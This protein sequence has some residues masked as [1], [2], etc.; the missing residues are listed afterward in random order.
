[1][2]IYPELSYTDQKVDI[3]EVKGIQ[4]SV[5]GPDEIIAR[6]VVEVNRTDTYNY[7]TVNASICG[8]PY[9]DIITNPITIEL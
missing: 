3:Q 5:L 4:F 2:S 6:S 8:I 9:T 7:V 1:M